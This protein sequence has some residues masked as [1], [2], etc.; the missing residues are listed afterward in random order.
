[1]ASGAGPGAGAERGQA[2]RGGGTSRAAALE[3]EHLESGYA[4]VMA[5]HDR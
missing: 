2:E 3:V 5:L 1:M 4:G